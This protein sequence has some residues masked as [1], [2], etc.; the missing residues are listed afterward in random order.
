VAA[1]PSRLNIYDAVA[2]NRWRTIALIVVFTGIL[3]ALGYVVGE[4]FVPGG[5]VAMIPVALGLSGVSATASYFAGDKLVL[6]Q[7]QAR[8]LASGEEPQLR[9]IVE[10]L[11]IGLGI[12]PP[13]I[14]VID[15]SAPNAF[16]TGRDPK[17]ASMAVTRG[18]LDKLDRTELE[19]VIAHELSH[20]VNR[21]IRVMLL[22]TVLVG[23]VALL[24]DWMLRSF[25]WGGGGRR[26]RDRGGGGIFLIIALALAILTPIIATLIQLAVSRQREYLADASGALLTRYPPGLANALRKIG[27]DKE[28]LEVANKATASLYF[29]NPLK[30]APRAMDGL[31]DTHPP[32][33]ERIRRLES[34]G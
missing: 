31:F 1:Q 22:V 15:D 10:T 17:H 9:N 21:D 20:V 30:D 29:A 13:R 14:Y 23:T 2:A 4:V 18:L 5:G 16:A 12:T 3:I 32:I 11:S 6:A 7:S 8:E 26:G 25:A 28:A 24:S 19:G 33:A 34:M 27:A